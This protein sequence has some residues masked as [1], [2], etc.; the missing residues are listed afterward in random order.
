MSVINLNQ[1]PTENVLRILGETNATVV[2]YL[3]GL[4][5]SDVRELVGGTGGRNTT[6]TVTALAGSGLQE[7][8]RRDYNY[9]RLDLADDATIGTFTGVVYVPDTAVQDQVEQQVLLAAGVHPDGVE[10]TD[11]VPLVEGDPDSEGSITM[12]PVAGSL[13]YVGSVVVELR[14]Y[15]PTVADVAPTVDLVGFTAPS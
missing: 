3:S 10:F 8:T 9:I 5:V 15:V 2:P 1:T 6:V 11:Y 7:G 13:L 14:P 12:N 4:S